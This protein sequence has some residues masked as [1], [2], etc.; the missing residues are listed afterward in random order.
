M[1]WDPRIT[2]EPNM[3]LALAVQKHN[4]WGGEVPVTPF[5]WRTLAHT[6][7][8]SGTTA[9]GLLLLCEHMCVRVCMCVFTGIYL[10]IYEGPRAKGICHPA[11]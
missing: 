4:R 2:S 6:H 9:P 3:R 5:R 10:S 8:Q 1:C 11:M 7:T